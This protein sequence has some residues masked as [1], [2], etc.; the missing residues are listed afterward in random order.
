MSDFLMPDLNAAF[1][2]LNKPFILFGKKKLPSG[3]HFFI[4]LTKSFLLVF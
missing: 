2:N 4:K 1:K 3:F